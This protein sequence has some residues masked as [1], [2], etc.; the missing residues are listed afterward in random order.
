MSFRGE[1]C[2][3]I[4]KSLMKPPTAQIAGAARYSE[5][6]VDEMVRSWSHFSNEA[7]VGRDVLD[8]GCGDGPAFVPPCAD[9]IAALD[10]RR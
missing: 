6:R 9:G 4:S 7:V 5:W 3:R 8:F 1:L 10:P 2:F